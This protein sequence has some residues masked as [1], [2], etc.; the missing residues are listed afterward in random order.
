VTFRARTF[1]V[2]LLSCAVA[3]AVAV[4]LLTSGMRQEMVADLEARLLQQAR[5]SAALL[6]GLDMADADAEADA[7][8]RLNGARVTLIAADGTVLGDSEVAAAD[9][10]ALEN[11]AGLEEVRAAAAGGSGRAIRYSQTTN[12]DTL[13]AAIG[14]PGPRAAVVRVALP[15]TDIDRRLAFVRRVA[16]VGLGA[17]LVVALFVTWI[18]SLVLSRRIRTIAAVAERYRRGDF[19]QPP[20]GYGRDEI[21]LVAGALDNTA[22]ELGRR[23]NEMARERAHTDAILGGMREGVILVNSAGRLVLT[24]PAVRSML[25]LPEPATDRPYLEVVRDPAITAQLAQA[26]AGGRPAPVEAQL[27]G[28][29]PRIYLAN[30]VPVGTERGGGAVLVLH[31]VTDIRRADQVR[32]DFVANVSH[33]L[34]TPLTAVRGY[35][36][37][38]ADDAPT[39]QQRRF[40]DIIARHTL[41]MERLVRDLLRLARLDAGQEPLERAH[42]TLSALAGAV[43][44][45][46]QVQTDARRQ[47]VRLDIA[48]DATH[49]TADPAKLHDILRNLV[50]NAS[51]YGPEG[52]TIEIR[53]ARDS[54]AIVLSVLDRGPGI[55]DAEIPRIFER[56][57]RVDRSR[58]RDPGGTG[59]GLSIVRHLVELHGGQVAA[60][61]REG[62][63]AEVSVR[64]PLEE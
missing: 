37:A 54:G 35:V 33:E 36:E 22:R 19:S 16:A 48:P 9:L 28:D 27:D 61:N 2:V 53:T 43:A 44:H 42:C 39:E 10:A 14:G 47:D 8:G 13:Y 52:S 23:L 64:L 6:A 29:R 31:D 56:F 59:L 3:L 20:R 57:Y 7:L 26:L 21:G 58:T 55:P 5:L 30:A 38:L 12:A 11:H 45:D 49:V 15:L 4:A 63:G 34:R 17:G 50:E 32:R 25:R 60:R 41:R 51:N 24:N 40:L 62:G 46:M 1:I 18:A